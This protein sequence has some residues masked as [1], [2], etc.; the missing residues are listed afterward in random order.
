[1]EKGRAFFLIA[2][3]KK[4]MDL[5]TLQDV[6]DPVTD[7]ERQSWLLRSLLMHSQMRTAPGDLRSRFAFWDKVINVK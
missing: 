4:V 3:K 1:M 7:H 5:K 2:W 6:G